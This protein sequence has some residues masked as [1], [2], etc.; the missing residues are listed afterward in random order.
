MGMSDEFGIYFTMK[1]IEGEDLKDVLDKLQANASFYEKTYPL[2][3]LLEIFLSVCNGV[4]YA[5]S[6]GIIHRDLKPANIMVG[7]YGEVL[8]LDWGL[9]KHIGAAEDS[10]GKVQLDMEESDNGFNTI[11]G[12]ISGTPNYMS[13]EQADGRIKDVDFQSDVY[14]LG[15]ILYHLLTYHPAFEKTRIRQLLQ[16][17]KEGRF[18]PPRKRFPERRIPIEL[19]AI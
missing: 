4:A 11:D 9:V 12:A 8:I 19:E 16:N 7:Q 2:H 14:S 5:H 6:R 17:V 13:P 1:K 15:A 18:T 10:D 3:F